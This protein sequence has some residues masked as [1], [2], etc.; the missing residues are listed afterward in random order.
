MEALARWLEGHAR[1]VLGFA[2]LGA[3]VA[4][5]FGFSVAGRLSP[6]GVDDPATQSVQVRHRFAQI[7]K[8]Q[9]EAG[10]IAVV[11]TQ[12]V[13]SPQ[14]TATVTRVEH[15]LARGPDVARVVTFLQTHNPAMVSRDGRDTYLLGYFKPYSDK[16]IADDARQ[17]EHR[18]A[19]RDVI[20]GGSAI[21]N[22]EVNS[23]V[24][25]DLARAELFVFPL[26]F[27]LSLLF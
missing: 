9:I 18:F 22:A 7:T 26:V 21:A 1:P 20:L 6:Y 25:H 13:R 14:G 2:V 5:I 24:S 23:H 16:R 27:L 10:V 11:R 17:I 15:E 19:S 12:G 8:H 3:I 4:G